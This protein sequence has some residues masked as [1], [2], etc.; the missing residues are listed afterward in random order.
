MEGND[1]GDIP[2]MSIG[3]VGIIG[4]MNGFGIMRLGSMRGMKGDCSPAHMLMSMAIIR[5]SCCLPMMS[6]CSRRFA[7][8]SFLLFLISPSGQKWQ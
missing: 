7:T 8:F 5:G 3:I 6:S 2:G 1:K 4:I